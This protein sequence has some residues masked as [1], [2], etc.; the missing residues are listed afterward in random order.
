MEWIAIKFFII[1]SKFG[2]FFVPEN[3]D[4]QYFHKVYGLCRSPLLY[5]I[6]GSHQLAKIHIACDFRRTQ[7]IPGI[8][9]SNKLKSTKSMLDIIVFHRNSWKKLSMSK[10]LNN[11]LPAKHSRVH[12]KQC[13]THTAHDGYMAF[14]LLNLDW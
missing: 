4:I 10:T 8:V 12:I 11:E 7:H 13:G 2:Y 6:S 5:Y 14:S 1:D 9:Y 3:R